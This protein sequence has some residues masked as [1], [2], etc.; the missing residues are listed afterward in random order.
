MTERSILINASLLSRCILAETTAM[1]LHIL[2]IDYFS[3]GS[4]EDFFR[5][6]QIGEQ[7]TPFIPTVQVCLL[8]E[9]KFM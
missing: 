8:Y 5:E 2:A 6:R 1:Y 4:T 7:F 9:T 3:F